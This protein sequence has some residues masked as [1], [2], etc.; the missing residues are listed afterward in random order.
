MIKVGCCGWAEAQQKYFKDFGVIEIQETFYQPG[1]ISK[2]EKWRAAAPDDFEFVLKCW[3]LVTHD[4]KTYRIQISQPKNYGFFKP[5]KEVFKAW[6]VMDRIAKTLKTKIVLF[7][8]PPSFGPENSENLRKFFEK[9]EHNYIFV[10]E[11]RGK[12]QAEQIEKICKE[13]ELVHC[14]DPLKQKSVVGKIN[15]FRLHGFPGYN[16]YYKYGK[17]DFVKIKNACNRKINYV[18]FNNLS[19]LKD[20]KRF[21]KFLK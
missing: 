1:K 6:N 19:M 5:T 7:Q 11:P 12:W 18:M 3:Q 9:I 8:T 4:P 20:A 16:L 14:V 21:Q 13:L 17:E 15:Y 2:Y 10:W